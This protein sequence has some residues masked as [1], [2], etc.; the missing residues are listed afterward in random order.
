LPDVD[1]DSPREK[2]AVL[3]RVAAQVEHALMV[4]YLYAGYSCAPPQRSIL[5][6][7]IEEMSHLMT[8]Q[9]LLRCLGEPPH[10][11]RQEDSAPVPE[12]DRLYPFGF[13]LEPL[14]E[15]SLAKYVV[16]E[17]PPSAP[18]DVDATVLAHIVDLATGAAHQPVNR[19][20]TLYALLGAVFGTEEVLHEHAVEGDAWYVAVDQMAA[21]AA[22]F[23]GG[24]DALHLPDGVFGGLTA[25]G[26]ASDADWDR[27]VEKEDLD[28]FRVHLVTSRSDA[29]DALRDIGLQGEGPSA[30]PSETAHFKRFYDL[31]V[32]FFG[33]NPS[34]PAVKRRNG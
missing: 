28:E 6:V 31:F 32:R 19:V 14:S 16:A 27:S 11:V 15:Q 20:G 12:E 26:Q 1:K 10:L 17:S 18:S 33:P 2:A 30:V 3:L 34:P 13:R 22:K 21:E 25:A 8:V 9:N 4:Q 24:R 7:A 23:Y 5:D 29:L